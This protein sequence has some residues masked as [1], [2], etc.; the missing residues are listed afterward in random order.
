MGRQH[1]PASVRLYERRH[2]PAGAEGILE[3]RDGAR[4][5]QRRRR[6]S[7]IAHPRSPRSDAARESLGSDDSSIG[8]GTHADVNSALKVVGLRR[9]G[10]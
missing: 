10:T 7:P 4:R 8:H 2:E 3:R 5:M 6:R 9:S 1:R